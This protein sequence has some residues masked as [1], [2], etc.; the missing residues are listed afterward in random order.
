ML[1]TIWINSSFS[2]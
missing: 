1:L 2:W